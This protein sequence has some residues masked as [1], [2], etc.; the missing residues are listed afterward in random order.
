[1]N[2]PRARKSLLDPVKEPCSNK[3]AD[4]CFLPN[5]FFRKSFLFKVADPFSPDGRM[6][7]GRMHMEPAHQKLDFPE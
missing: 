4:F 6:G 1:M 5:V 7:L 3:L 2:A